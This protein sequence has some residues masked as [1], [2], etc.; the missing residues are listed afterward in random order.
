MRLLQRLGI[1]RD[2]ADRLPLADARFVVVDVETTGLNPR[3]DELLS[4]GLVPAGLGGVDLGGLREIVLQHESA[5]VDRDNVVVHGISPTESAGG[6]EK[7]A[8]LQEF[9]TLVRDGRLVAFHAEFDRQVLSRALRRYL[10]VR[11]A[12]PF[13]D[14][15]WLLPALFPAS[16][17]GRQTLDDWLDRFGIDAPYRHRAS[18]DALVTAE[19]LMVALAE[20]RRQRVR[21]VAAMAE[22]ANVHGKLVRMMPEGS[23]R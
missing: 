5:V 14:L 7:A 2:A 11:F 1:G 20:A 15:A 22:M 8:A 21:D 17:R 18:A 9:L 23:S 16:A 12:S 4:I 19:L 3:R 10:K 13:I 6:V